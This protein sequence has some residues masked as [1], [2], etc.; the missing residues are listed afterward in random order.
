MSTASV[1][2]WPDRCRH[3]LLFELLGLACLVP[4]GS[5]FLHEDS[6]TLGGLGLLLSLLAMGWNGLYNA[7]FDRLELHRGGHLSRRTWVARLVQAVGFEVGLTALSLPILMLALDL[8][9]G[10]AFVLDLGLGLFYVLFGLFFNRAYDRVFP[11]HEA[12]HHC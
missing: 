9:L 8:S 4:L 2:S 7:L 3:S 10:A 12:S 11:L 6:L 5:L 1:R